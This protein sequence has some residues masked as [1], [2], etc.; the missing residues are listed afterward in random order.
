[1]ILSP[2]ALIAGTKKSPHP[3]NRR[4]E[5]LLNITNRI[6]RNYVVP[7]RSAVLH[8]FIKM[9]FIPV[10]GGGH[11]SILKWYCNLDRSVQHRTRKYKQFLKTGVK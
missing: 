7:A 11:Y 9:V 4:L 3:L 6:S 1:M 8:V 2:E 10:W 5:R